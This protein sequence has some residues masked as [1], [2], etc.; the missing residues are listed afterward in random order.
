MMFWAILIAVLLFALDRHLRDK[1]ERERNER[2][3][4]YDADDANT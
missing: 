1:R 4:H 3:E 2:N